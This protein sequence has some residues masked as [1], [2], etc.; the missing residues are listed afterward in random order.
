M[1]DEYKA[2]DGKPE[3]ARQP[4]EDT[5]GHRA[6][7]GKSDEPG[8]EAKRRV[9]LRDGEHDVEGHRKFTDDDEDVE[10]HRK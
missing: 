6:P 5:E 1:G 3:D 7:T 2:K 9:P 4:R 8:P 10:G